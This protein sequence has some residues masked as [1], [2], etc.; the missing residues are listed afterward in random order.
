M[1]KN[2]RRF[3]TLGCIGIAVFMT[4]ISLYLLLETWGMI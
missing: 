3:E 2:E 4:A 1:T